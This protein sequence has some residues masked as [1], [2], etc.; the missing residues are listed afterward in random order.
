MLFRSVLYTLYVQMLTYSSS[1][2]SYDLT[3]S[4]AETTVLVIYQQSFAAVDPINS[5]ETFVNSLSR[6]LSMSLLPTAKVDKVCR[7]AT[8]TPT[9]AHSHSHA[10]VLLCLLITTTTHTIDRYVVVATVHFHWCY[11]F[12]IVNL[13]STRPRISKLEFF[14]ALAQVV[15]AQTGKGM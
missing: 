15:L 12:K 13:V 4:I 5:G 10:L 1:L 3:I 8:R 6:V 14:V 2:G 11:H 7:S 9:T